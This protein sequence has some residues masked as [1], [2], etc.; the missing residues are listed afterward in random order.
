MKRGLV[1]ALVVALGAAGDAFELAGALVAEADSSPSA[2]SSASSESRFLRSSPRTCSTRP[3]MTLSG[4]LNAGILSLPSR[5]TFFSWS[6]L[7]LA[8]HSAVVRSRALTMV[9]DGPSP[10]PRFP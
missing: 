3:A 2:A 5:I 8:C 7:T 1:V 6:S 10:R 9:D 4:R